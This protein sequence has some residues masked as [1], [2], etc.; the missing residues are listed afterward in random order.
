MVNPNNFRF[1]PDEIPQVPIVFSEEAKEWWREQKRR[2][3]E[4]YW[5]SGRWMPGNL[6]FYINFWPILLAKDVYSKVKVKG[7]PHLW[8][9]HWELF[10]GWAE[11]RGLTGFEGQPEVMELKKAMDSR[12]LTEE[13]EQNLRS[14]ITPIREVLFNTTKDLG[15]PLYLN[16]AK[17]FMMLGNRGCGKSYSVAGGIIGHEFLFDGLKE[18]KAG[19]EITESA[20]IGVAAGDEHH[21]GI[22]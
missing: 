9:I 20:E 5:N 19:S 7:M 11:A 14:K 12:I 16:E 13:E 4:G 15:K 6:Y 2:C 22:G 1:S 8:D 21:G 17:D 10:Y 3:I 18:Y